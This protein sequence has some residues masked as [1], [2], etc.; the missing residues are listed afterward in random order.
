MNGQTLNRRTF[1]GSLAAAG[2]AFLLPSVTR[3]APLAGALAPAMLIASRSIPAVM[4]SFRTTGF[5]ADG[6]GGGALY[7]RVAA[8]PAHA[9]ALQDANGAWYEG[10]AENGFID[11]A[12]LGALGRSSNE[13]PA[14]QRALDA[15]IAK[16]SWLR[17][18]SGATYV[19]DPSKAAG[20]G[21]M[22]LP[23]NGQSVRIDF[24]GATLKFA[25]NLP[26]DKGRFWHLFSVPLQSARGGRN[27]RV[28][29]VHLRGPRLDGNA[30]S[31]PRPV[32][33]SDYEQRSL[34]RVAAH[35]GNRIERVIIE[36]AWI[37]DRIADGL[38]IGNST[39]ESDGPRAP[40]ARCD[41]IRPR[42]GPADNAVRAF[43]GV[44]SGCS[45]TRIV[46]P[47]A[48]PRRAGG[49]YNS[50]ETEFSSIGSQKVLLEIEGGTVDALELGA[51]SD[52]RDHRDF[53]VLATNLT[54]R[55]YYVHVGGSIET[56]DCDFA[57]GLKN[58]FAV[59]EALHRNTLF[60]HA[61]EESG[62]VCRIAIRADWVPIND[63]RE[64]N[65]RHILS[66]APSAGAKNPAF[67]MLPTE[68]GKQDD[69]RLH[70]TGCSFD[71]RFPMAI[72]GYGGGSV[73]TRDCRMGGRLAGVRTGSFG[74]YAGTYVSQGD[75]WGS[76]GA[77]V[78]VEIIGNVARNARHRIEGGRFGGKSIKLRGRFARQSIA[79]IPPGVRLDS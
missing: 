2:G 36:D 66:S 11:A 4:E 77:P 47:Q 9:F 1:V 40:I 74:K 59:R 24:N 52:M 75:D 54:L 17:L 64:E 35:D 13:I 39:S 15:A 10:Q 63:W 60:R 73:V 6:D 70:L 23:R 38:I 76:V 19:C 49:R 43:I 44:G 20:N 25:D 12:A 62:E 45:H 32:G 30:R 21:W 18:K 69:I 68:A 50:I 5:R 58:A 28:P 37:E 51:P 67:K 61:T 16:D 55:D 34:I 71:P 78:A 26:R 79:A 41:I 46:D 57:I 72:D 53:K 29:L 3:G 65:C 14:L 7:R 48:A 27:R 8:R 42:C 31:Q 22:A 33:R 56:R